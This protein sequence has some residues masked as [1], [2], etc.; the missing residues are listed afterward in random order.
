MRRSAFLKRMAFAAMACAFIDV[1][2]L[3]AIE[4]GPFM[5]FSAVAD[6]DA[7]WIQARIDASP[8]GH[9]TLPPGDYVLGTTVHVPEDVALD[10]CDSRITFSGD[11][12]PA[13]YFHG[14]PHPKTRI[15]GN[16]LDGGYLFHGIRTPAPLRL[17]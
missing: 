15:H 6:D 4:T 17:A 13:L 7:P 8:G 10:W 16:V 9:V 5:G 14:Q 11:D 3:G 12:G 1:P 2:K